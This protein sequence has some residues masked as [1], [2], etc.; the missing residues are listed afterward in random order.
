MCTVFSM[1]NEALLAEIKDLARLWDEV[2]ARVKD[3]EDL[4]GEP[5]VASLN[6]LRYGGRRFVDLVHL[7]L[8]GESPNTDDVRLILFEAKQNCIRARHDAIDSLY[9]EAREYFKSA[10]KTFNITII[11]KIYPQYLEVQKIMRD[12]GRVISQS[13]EQRAKRPELYETIWK[14]QLPQIM[15][16]Y[17]ALRT[18]EERLIEELAQAQA[19]AREKDET[20]KTLQQLLDAQTETRA[21]QNETKLLL[22]DST[23]TSELGRAKAETALRKAERKNTVLGVIAI[24]LG[25]I[26]L[27]PIFFGA[28]TNS[29]VAKPSPVPAQSVPP[30]LSPNVPLGQSAPDPSAQPPK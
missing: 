27:Y 19:E 8:T 29:S 25:V 24:I 3:A 9:F 13:R 14:D 18:S 11:T 1:S 15:D 23:R 5:V 30:A 6:E 22:E 20:I 4:L 12:A 17:H 16:A 21:A 7:A 28:E 2:E 26:A 10:E